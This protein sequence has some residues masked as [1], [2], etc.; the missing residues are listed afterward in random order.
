[1]DSLEEREIP[2]TDGATYPFWS[3]DGTHIAFFAQGK[4]KQVAASGGPATNIADAPDGRGGTWGTDGT[5]VFAPSVNGGLSQVSPA[6]G[7]AATPLKLPLRDKDSLRFPTFLPD[8]GRFFYA[9]LD[10][11]ARGEMVAGLYVGSLDGS[12]PVRLLPDQSVARFVNGHILFAREETLMAQPFDAA[13]LK[14]TGEAFPLAEGL[15]FTGNVGNTAFTT[16]SNGTL[17]YLAGGGGAQEREIAWLDRSGRRAKTLVKQKG[18]L[19]PT[20]SPDER[21]VA[22]IDG[23]VSDEGD[24]WLHDIAQGTSQRFT[25]GPYAALWPEWSSDSASVVFSALPN[26]ELFQKS[27]RTSAKEESLKVIGTNTRVSSWQ[28]DG[29]LLAYS[30][31]GD[32]TKDDLWLLP[33]EG[34]RKP[35]LFKQTPFAERSGQI[36]PDGRWMVYSSDASGQSEIYI[37]PMPSGGAQR[38]ISIGGGG[39]P[40]WRKDGREL[41]FIKSG[42]KLM[43]VDV[44]PGPE[45]TFGTPRELFT[46]NL[47]AEPRSR[48]VYPN[49]DGSQFL[50]LL[51]VG[52]AP[53]APPL[54]VVTNWLH[55]YGK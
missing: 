10:Q 33:L 2:G 31:T 42:N 19:G 24:V 46:S 12:A 44:K 50:A 48:A 26:Y 36:S 28:S 6:T 45:L 18:L 14:L 30:Q 5:I 43:V 21:R 34:D 35:K 3:P 47:I 8:S 17:L 9:Y 16:A 39:N 37:E 11:G 23:K 40:S 55:A 41:Y 51:P 15:T 22:Y 32:S 20:L 54:T 27:I 53:A 38:Q 13:A 29:K 1:M 52:D 49:A 25:F 7:G 4:L